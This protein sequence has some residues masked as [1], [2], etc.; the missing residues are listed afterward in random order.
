M[1]TETPVAQPNEIFHLTNRDEVFHTVHGGLRKEKCYR[2]MNKTS[3]WV[4]KSGTDES[5]IRDTEEEVNLES[6]W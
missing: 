5:R 6:C 2:Q 4:V 3:I 1:D